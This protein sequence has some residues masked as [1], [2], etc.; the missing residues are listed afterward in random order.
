MC[1]GLWGRRIGMAA[2]LCLALAGAVH[3]RGLLG[4]FADE[5]E[6]VPV[7]PAPAAPEPGVNAVPDRPLAWISALRDVSDPAA[8]LYGYVTAGTR[9]DLGA[10][11]EMTLTWLSP[12]REDSIVG[13][14]VTVTRSGPRVSGAPAPHSRV[15]SC[16]PLDLVLPGPGRGHGPVAVNS[17]E[18]LFAWPAARD[19]PARLRL[20]DIG[21]AEPVEVWSATVDG[22]AAPYPHEAPLIEEGRSYRIESAFEDGTVY[23]ATFSFDPGLRFSNAP[24]NALV[25]LR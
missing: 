11:G 12:C 16:Q 10:D 3:A 5:P 8:R 20:L 24:I 21:A 15:L 14:V 7:T 6:A 23:A 17:S 4:L 18:P 25:M 2:A 22:N 9:I 1:A 19:M 13:G